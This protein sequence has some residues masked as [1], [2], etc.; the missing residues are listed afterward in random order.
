MRKRDRSFQRTLRSLTLCVPRYHERRMRRT[1][2]EVFQKAQ[3]VKNC[4]HLNDACSFLISAYQATLM[5]FAVDFDPASPNV[6]VN[7]TDSPLVPVP[8]ALNTV[9]S[10]ES[11]GEYRFS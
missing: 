6:T 4:M 11:P 1:S 7:V 2:S 9:I 3:V 8:V 5:P 10:A